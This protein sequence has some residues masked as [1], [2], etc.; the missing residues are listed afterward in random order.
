MTNILTYNGIRNATLDEAFNVGLNPSGPRSVQVDMLK[1][2]SD[3]NQ[4]TGYE[5]VTVAYSRPTS[6]YQYQLWLDA[7]PASSTY[8]Q[9]Y[10]YQNGAW[11]L[12]GAAS[13]AFTPDTVSSSMPFI[14][15]DPTTGAFLG[16]T[17][18]PGASLL[19]DWSFQNDKLDDH[20]LIVSRSGL[21]MKGGTP[22]RHLGVCMYDGI[23]DTYQ[24]HTNYIADLQTLALAGVKI[25][26]V[27]AGSANDATDW[28]THIGTD[29]TAPLSGYVTA[30]TS[31]L[32][33]CAKNGIACIPTLL[34]SHVTIAQVVSG[35]VADYTNSSS[36]VRNYCRNFAGW[37][38]KTFA[39]HNG[40]AAW[41]IGN[42]WTNQ[43]A[44]SQFITS[45]YNPGV[46]HDTPY[47]ATVNDVYA[48][49]RTYDK[50]RA[51]AAPVGN[52]SYF[53]SG[54]F[55]KW[56]SRLVGWAGN[57]EIV[58]YHY[59]PD[60]D[61]SIN[62]RH[63]AV[64]EDLG[65]SQ[66][67]LSSIRG[68]C[69]RSGKAL[70]IEECNA[71]FD[72]PPGSI[73]SKSYDYSFNT[74]VELVLDWNWYCNS[75][76]FGGSSDNLK[77]T[78]SAVLA[79]IAGYNNTLSAAPKLPPRTLP[80]YGTLA[81]PATCFRSQQGTSNSWVRLPINTALQPAVG[82]P[83]CI[84]FWMRK[85]ARLAA[86][87]RIIACEDGTGGFFISSSLSGNPENL[88]AQFAFNGSYG[89]GIFSGNP[90]H[91]SAPPGEWHHYCFAYD[92]GTKFTY[93]FDGL[94]RVRNVQP[95]VTAYATTTR[96]TFIGA[97]SDGLSSASVDIMDL[98]ISHTYPTSQQVHTYFI[99]GDVPA[100]TSHRWKLSADG[101]DS[102]GI[103]D[104]TVGSGASFVASGIGIGI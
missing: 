51:I 1:A 70:V 22:L 56:A 75:S 50:V 91:P 103:L 4:N 84:M 31:F 73:A 85:T 15:T 3:T 39:D 49:L 87:T 6:P 48:T 97:S 19:P 27:A 41:G 104:A 20:R 78:R 26:R 38:A 47:L 83:F 11:S 25:I 57:C 102:I 101:K 98:M 65:A 60:S 92:G 10:L 59:Y 68:A 7:N 54:D 43:V 58:T 63:F 18:S 35:T 62:D 34:W 2:L 29:G 79:T 45:S 64:G 77:T 61:T 5:M 30:V 96:N 14:Q 90:P 94:V 86:N 52:A 12:Q 67:V 99:A 95:L 21:L 16:L 9:F 40:I 8:K 80:L 24:G 89:G 93:W 66:T 53:V 28:A 72:S 69:I 46:D 82:Q 71:G 44:I 32:D 100:G 23:I 55:P 42:E 33:E 76:S 81:I 37:W 36:D 13:P 88:D 74:G 17:Y